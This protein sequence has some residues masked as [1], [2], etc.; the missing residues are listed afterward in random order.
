MTRKHYAHVVKGFHIPA[1]CDQ[2][3]SKRL[4]YCH[5]M[6]VVEIRYYSPDDASFWRML[7]IG[8]WS[9]T[10]WRVWTLNVWMMC[11]YGWQPTGCCLIAAR[12]KHSGVQLFAAD[13]RSWPDLFESVVHNHSPSFEIS[14]STWML[15][16]PCVPTWLQSFGR[17]MLHFGRYVLCDIH[18]HLRPCWL[19]FVHSLSASWT[20]ATP[21][22]SGHQKFY[23]AV[24]SRYSTPLPGW[25]FRQESL[26]ISSLLRE[27]HQVSIMR[28]DVPLSSWW[29]TELP[30]W[31]HPP[32]FQLLSAASPLIYQHVSSHRPVDSSLVTWRPCVPDGCSKSLEVRT[33]YHLLSGV[34]IHWLSSAENSRLFYFNRHSMSTNYWHTHPH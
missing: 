25:Y 16:S 34:L 5:P 33:P 32:S 3:W 4:C 7:S 31:D 9:T 18:C 17:V 26:N 10:E 28:V 22:W 27:L 12:R 24:T 13:T 8:N 15:T 29:G 14:G 23:C 21:C 6:Y 20:T 2:R 30:C 11:R 19:C 1:F